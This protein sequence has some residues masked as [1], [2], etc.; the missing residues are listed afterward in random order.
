LKTTMKRNLLGPTVLLLLGST[1]SPTTACANEDDP[2]KAQAQ[3]TPEQE[4]LPASD[5]AAE[6]PLDPAQL[7]SVVARVDG[8]DITK[9]ELLGRAKE[10][11]QQLRIN[12]ES[13]GF[14]LKVLDD[15]IGTELLYQA[16]VKDGLAP[17]K[18]DVDKQLNT[19]RGNFTSE[20]QFAERLSADGL[21]IEK[22]EQMIELSR[23][24]PREPS[25]K[26]TSSR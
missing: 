1:M 12:D 21:S 2:G 9:D 22:L 17:T 7:P 6:A 13:T 15:L 20:E 25:M 23:K 24:K 26:R 5:P 19:I 16:S 11:Q 10:V 8:E 3:T 14:Y 4:K 18:E